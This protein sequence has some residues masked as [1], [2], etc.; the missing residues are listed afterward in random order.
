MYVITQFNYE[1]AQYYLEQAQILANEIG[2][3]RW[4]N[5]NEYFLG[6]LEANAGNDHIALRHFLHGYFQT[7]ANSD[8]LALIMTEMTSILWSEGMGNKISLS[9]LEN[10]KKITAMRPNPNPFIEGRILSE[11]CN[12]YSDSGELEK[13]I[14]YFQLTEN[15]YAE[16]PRKFPFSSIALDLKISKAQILLMQDDSKTAHQILSEVF[17]QLPNYSFNISLHIRLLY[18]YAMALIAV[19]DFQ[20]A[21]HYC[22]LGLDLSKK[23]HP[24]IKFPEIV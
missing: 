2:E 24:K 3:S 14:T 11:F 16:I 1:K 18:V 12:I 6:V 5:L 21:L 7:S 9:L 23:K 8:Y 20:N 10:A 15:A 4:I 13:A 17:L 22:Q 19:Q